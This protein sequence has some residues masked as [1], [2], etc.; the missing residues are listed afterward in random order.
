GKPDLLISQ[1][2]GVDAGDSFVTVL[3]GNGD[4]TFRAPVH[5]DAGV[6][7]FGLAVGDFD[8]DGKLD[9]AVEELDNFFPGA[10][11][12]FLGNGDGTFGAGHV[13]RTGGDAGFGVAAG[14]FN[15]DGRPDLAVANTFSNDVRVLLNT[16]TL[17]TATTLST[18]VN[19]ALV[20][21]V[22]NLTATVTGPA[23]PPTGPVP[24]L[25][26]D[27]VL[28]TATLD[29]TGTASLAVAFATAGD[30]A[31]TA[32]YGGQAFSAASSSAALTETVTP[33]NSA[34]FAPPGSFPPRAGP[35]SGHRGHF[36]PHRVPRHLTADH[37]D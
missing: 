33:T 30:H 20:G 32:V 16:T 12:V 29:D 36:H 15:G 27:A 34:R 13:F 18:D 24:F 1:F 28:G 6:D 31:L 10:A 22:V 17:A 26:G 23:G 3:L 14:D 21:Q 11:D 37:A 25:D 2:V 19:P 7:R 8:G 9:V 4:G 35:G 5:T